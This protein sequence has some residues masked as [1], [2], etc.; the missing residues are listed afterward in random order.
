MFR[1]QTGAPVLFGNGRQVNSAAGGSLIAFSGR[2]DFVLAF[3]ENDP[4]ASRRSVEHSVGSSALPTCG[5]RSA[6]GST[7]RRMNGNP[8]SSG[9]FPREPLYRVRARKGYEGVF[10][11]TGSVSWWRRMLS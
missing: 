3:S 5:G 6:A 10:E 11:Q 2:N 8:F 7:R 9:S 4:A 1:D